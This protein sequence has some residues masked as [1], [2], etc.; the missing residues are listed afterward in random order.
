[1]LNTYYPATYQQDESDRLAV[2]FQ[3]PN[4]IFGFDTHQAAYLLKI[5]DL[6]YNEHPKFT[7]YATV[8]GLTE[9][10]KGR[11]QIEI[12]CR[13]TAVNPAADIP[14]AGVE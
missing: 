10:I 11:S 2:L 4:S 12:F 13:K 5:G 9:R 6:L 8:V 3:E 7:G 14:E 1:M